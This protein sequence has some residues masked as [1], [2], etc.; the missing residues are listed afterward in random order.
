L[1]EWRADEPAMI[2]FKIFTRGRAR[3]APDQSTQRS[4]NTAM[5]AQ[6]NTVTAL[7]FIPLAA[8]ITYMDV[9]YRRIPN[10]L[11][12]LTLLGGITLNTVFSGS[13]GFI[14][15]LVGLAVAFGLMFF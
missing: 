6:P 9:R 12:L 3:L 15:S 2:L 11:V 7:L 8:A 10:T 5:L 13:R 4:R 14:V 1:G